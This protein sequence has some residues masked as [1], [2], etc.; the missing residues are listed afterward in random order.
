MG[1]NRKTTGSLGHLLKEQLSQSDDGRAL[2]AEHQYRQEKTEAEQKEQDRQQ[3]EKE[4]ERKRILAEKK[5]LEEARKQRMAAAREKL[6][7]ANAL[8]EEARA[9]AKKDFDA[10]RNQ[11][12]EKKSSQ[13]TTAS[14]TVPSL[15][16]NSEYLLQNN[17]FHIP[18]RSGLA[19]R[20]QSN[21]SQ[22]VT[23]GI[24]MPELYMGIDFGS[25]HTKVIIRE[26]GSKRAYAVPFSANDANPYLVPS[27]IHR[28]GSALSLF[29]REQCSSTTDLKRKLV[30]SSSFE[31][32]EVDDTIFFLALVIRTARTWFLESHADDFVDCEFEWV[33][34]LG[35]PARDFSDLELVSKYQYVGK[36]ALNLANS[37]SQIVSDFDLI[38]A[39]K[40]LP[41]GYP[42]EHIEIFPEVAAQLHG[43]V[44]SDRWDHRRNR[45]MLVDIGGSTIDSTLVNVR[46]ETDGTIRY[47]F[48]TT[49]VM[50]YGTLK[51]ENERI[52]S[53]REAKGIERHELIDQCLQT[54]LN[55]LHNITKT[56]DSI[57]D[58]VSN[59]DWSDDSG[60]TVDESYYRA[61]A[62]FL[63]DR[64]ISPAK[65]KVDRSPEAYKNL[66][67]FY[68]G[69]GSKIALFK[70]FVDK[71]NSSSTSAVSFQ[72][73]EEIP[74]K[75]IVNKG[76]SSSIYNRLSVAFGLAHEDL[77]E[78]VNP[79]NIPKLQNEP[80]LD[81]TDSPDFINKDMV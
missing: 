10:K 81:W 63:W 57:N 75:T 74:P 47:S 34:H 65:N 80:Q 48:L 5:L 43:Y 50:P 46:E 27:Q 9:R 66:L 67:L 38:S 18:D 55:N 33:Y 52:S 32:P 11:Q 59:L 19:S 7:A 26:S 56:P 4:A 28:L 72:L 16:S 69:G 2:L 36:C 77:G 79:E 60:I 64:I 73:I 15:H 20:E 6:D 58:Y 35:L 22:V 71:I 8:V 21:V 41:K 61:F 29:P 42:E 51:L 45:L 78:W 76:I 30:N 1:K 40:M 25:T 23:E 37:S 3:R 54:R 13:K 24:A 70:R 53:L 68:C 12:A 14:I 44:R 31:S 39:K 62:N 49:E 17:E